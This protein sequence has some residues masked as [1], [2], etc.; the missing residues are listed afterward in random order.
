MLA[1]VSALTEVDFAPED[2][3]SEVL[4]NLRTLL[5]TPKGSVS[6]DREFGIDCS[7][8]DNPSPV[9]MMQ[10]RVSVVQAVRE[11]EP[12]ATVK[13]VDFRPLPE[14]AMGGRLWPV[15][16]VEISDE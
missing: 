5:A 13:S 10:A 6:L 2:V 11:Y 16:T 8:V 9:A 4:Q 1:D 14:D 12:R 7:F 15:L 3:K